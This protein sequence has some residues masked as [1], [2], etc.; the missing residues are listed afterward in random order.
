MVSLSIARAVILITLLH[1]EGVKYRSRTDIVEDIL[2]I[3]QDGVLKT[4]IMYGAFLS[5]PQMKEYLELLIDSGLLKYSKE[6]K[7]YYTT[8]RGEYFLK[9]Y[10]EVG[11]MIS[12]KESKAIAQ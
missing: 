12:S 4:R 9:M 8:Q 1:I 10:K 11:H 5:F 6:E 7:K 3:A 2:Q